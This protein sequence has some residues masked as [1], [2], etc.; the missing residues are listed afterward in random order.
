M[1]TLGCTLTA[2]IH[3]LVQQ[4]AVKMHACWV[5]TTV[6]AYS[7]RLLHQKD[8][9]VPRLPHL[10]GMASVAACTTREVE[11]FRDSA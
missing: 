9:T 6:C 5:K 3:V 4:L 11:D 8:T 10:W 7:Y 2:G 1:M